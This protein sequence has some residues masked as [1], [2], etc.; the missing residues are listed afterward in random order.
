MFVPERRQFCTT[1]VKSGNWHFQNKALLRDFLTKWTF[2]ASKQNT[3]RLPPLLNLTASKAKQSCETSLKNGKLSADPT[4]LYQCVFLFF[5]SLHASKVLCL[6]GKKWGQVIRSSAP[7]MQNHLRKPQN[8]MLQNITLCRKSAPW[9]LNMSD[10]HVSCIE[11]SARNAS[12]KIYTRID[13][14]VLIKSFNCE[15]RSCYV[16]LCYVGNPR[17]VFSEFAKVI[18]YSRKFRESWI[19]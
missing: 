18:V 6:P 3:A 19:S 16:M 5:F 12:L 8:L 15:D 4:A 10:G 9:P 11:P 17:E 13:L 14:K 1:S 7:V 2:T